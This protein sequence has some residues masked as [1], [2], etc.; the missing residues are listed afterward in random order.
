MA[1]YDS[2]NLSVIDVATNNV[3]AIVNVGYHP[4]GVAFGHFIDSNTTGQSTGTNSSSTENSGVEETNL[5][6]EE[7][8]ALKLSSSNNNN[9]ESGNGSSSG[10]NESSK[11]SSTP[12]FGL[13]GGLAGLYGGWKFRKK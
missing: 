3:I 8:N 2:N 11:N 9:S 12:G 10:E 13:L 6:S 5:S 1:N 7:K 4:S